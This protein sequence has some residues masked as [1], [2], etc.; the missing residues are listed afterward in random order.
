MKKT[1]LITS[2]LLGL[3]VCSMTFVSCSD[4]NEEKVTTDVLKKIQ[5]M[6]QMENPG[7]WYDVWEITEKKLFILS[8]GDVQERYSYT[9]DKK[10]NIITLTDD[11]WDEDEPYIIY[12]KVI[13]VTDSKLYVQWYDLDDDEVLDENAEYTPFVFTRMN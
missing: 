5:G 12:V 1:L 11:G 7:D 4:D 9:F 10:T 3:V 8:E 13:T 6:W 2:L